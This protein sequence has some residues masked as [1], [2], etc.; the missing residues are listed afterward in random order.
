MQSLDELHY[1]LFDDNLNRKER[2]EFYREKTRELISDKLDLPKCKI[3]IIHDNNGKPYLN[4]FDNKIKISISHTHS[5]VAI[6]LSNI[7]NVAVDIEYLSDK[8]LKIRNKFISEKEAE[9]INIDDI[10]DTTLIWTSKETAY[11]YYSDSTKNINEYK[12][13]EIDRENKKIYIHTG[14]KLSYKV[15]KNHIITWV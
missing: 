12:I 13:L 4:N 8:I 5:A 7:N 3:N 14:L 11:K 1:I 10:I 6:R 9:L 2:L 15:L